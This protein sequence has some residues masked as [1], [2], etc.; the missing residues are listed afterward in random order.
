M[1]DLNDVRATL[2]VVHTNLR[3]IRARLEA[4]EP[5]VELLATMEALISTLPERVDD[6][7][8]RL[9]ADPMLGTLVAPM[10]V[11]QLQALAATIAER[12]G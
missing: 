2:G 8:K 11:P 12:R 3:E 4:M 6:M 10:L 9:E 7:C 1:D 5:M